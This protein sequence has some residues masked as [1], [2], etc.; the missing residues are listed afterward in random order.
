MS[1]DTRPIHH[2]HLVSFFPACR[3]QAGGAKSTPR[4]R[5]AA[6]KSLPKAR[7]RRIQKQ[8][9]VST[10][11]DRA[12][13]CRGRHATPHSAGTDTA[14]PVAACRDSSASSGDRA[15]AVSSPM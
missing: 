14:A 12:R 1:P 7:R 10:A 3:G 2:R 9:E 11:T 8:R 5:R 15:P 4:K 6:A 13:A